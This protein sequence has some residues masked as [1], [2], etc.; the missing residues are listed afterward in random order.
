MASSEVDFSVRVHS[1]SEW[2][3]SWALSLDVFDILLVWKWSWTLEGNILS[4]NEWEQLSLIKKT[5]VHEVIEIGTTENSVPIVDNMSSVHDLSE[6]IFEI[7]P[8]KLA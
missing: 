6:K 8:R 4:F 1:E 7:I 2:S 5:I 3:L